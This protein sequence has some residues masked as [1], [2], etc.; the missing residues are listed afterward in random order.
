MKTEAEKN[1][2]NNILSKLSDATTALASI[3]NRIMGRQTKSLISKSD[4]TKRTGS[5]WKRSYCSSCIWPNCATLVE[6]KDGVAVRIKGDPEAPFNKGTLC[7]R[8]AAQ[9]ANLYNPYR[10]KAPMKRTNPEKGLD[11]DPGWVEI[12]WEE[13]LKTVSEKLKAIR[14]TDPRKF[15]IKFGF[16]SH[17]HESHNPVFMSAAFGTPNAVMTSGPLCTVHYS[18][19]LHH[20]SYVDKIDLGYCNYLIAV[21]RTIGSNFM[22]ANGPGRALAEALERGMKLV[23]VDPRC[24]P[25]AS[26][27]E[28]IPIR[29]A[30]D[31]A[32]ALA[33]LN[34][35][36]HELNTYDVDTVKNRT[37]GPYLIGPDQDYVRHPET[38]KP[39]I[40]DPV[41]GEAREFDDQSIQDYALEGSFTVNGQQVRPA[42]DLMKEHVKGYSPEWA[43]ELTTIP[44]ETM[45]RMTGEYVEAACI[46][47]TITID[48]VV[49]PYRPVCIAALRGASNHLHGRNFHFLTGVINALMGASDVPGS[50]CGVFEGPEY[51]APGKDGTVEVKGELGYYYH[52]RK[53]Q[54]PPNNIELK[55]LY[56]ISLGQPQVMPRAVLDPKKHYLDY[57]VET[58]MVHGANAIMNNA[59]P[60]EVIDSYKKVPFSF[61]YAYE[62][63]EPTMLCDIV[64]PVT[65]TLDSYQMYYAHDIQAASSETINLHATNYKS[66]VVDPVYKGRQV[67]DITF[68]IAERVG[69]LHGQRGLNFIWNVGSKI[70]KSHQLDLDKR[71][72]YREVLDRRLRGQH[73]DDKGEE[74]FRENGWLSWRVPLSQNYNTYHN[75]GTRLEIYG[76][77]ML[78]VGRRF[79]A[80]LE[81]VG[82]AVPGWDMEEYFHYYKALPEWK[83]SYLFTA[84]EE[85]DLFVINWKISPRNLGIGAQDDNPWLREIIEE[86]E[87][88]GLCVQINRATAEAKG[89]Q[90]GDR[91]LLESQHG[92]TVEGILFTSEL[93]HPDIIGI[94]GQGGHYSRQMHPAARR[95]VHY[96]RLISSS[97]GHFCPSAG[98][99][100]IAARV[101]IFK[102]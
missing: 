76:R 52:G 34:I 66:P 27:G 61:S 65:A 67:E 20:G 39:L 64:L 15:V 95:G 13:A 45:R 10:V 47:E 85:F 6:V 88:G 8:G 26:K 35:I 96:N 31:L 40:W 60:Q 3:G 17:I 77:S 59:N 62:F 93:L 38:G 100:D 89:L 102:A 69:F 9:L 75:P 82:A 53:F 29:P 7:P 42:L 19:M 2:S 44:A 12:T 94:P 5:T 43:E 73:G 23:V 99:I 46:G 83:D 57:E 92:G 70:P 91:V 74:Y 98:G 33:M 16:S 36:L 4:T 41:S 97:E 81:N 32:L 18:P 28:W 37:N 87:H 86:W 55:E 30:T 49:Y 56:P 1:P 90:D 50:M 72:S 80:N 78:D 14:E 58:I 54:F 25:E 84:P 101:K 51:L 11:V 79:K 63:N 71:Y 48:G 68:E 21:G 24:S 22:M